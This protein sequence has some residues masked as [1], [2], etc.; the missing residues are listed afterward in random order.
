MSRRNLMSVLSCLSSIILRSRNTLTR[1]LMS[2]TVRE[3]DGAR[4]DPAR[5]GVSLVHLK[6]CENLESF[7]A[8]S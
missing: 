3:A 1:A 6:Y 8:E 5:W 4:T 7:T 2:H